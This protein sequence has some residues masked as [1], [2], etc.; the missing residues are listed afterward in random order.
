MNTKSIQST[1]CKEYPNL[2]IIS[3][4]KQSKVFSKHYSN[5]A[6]YLPRKQFVLLSWLVF[7]SGADNTFNHSTHLL[8]QFSAY[9]LAIQS[10]YGGETI[11]TAI[12]LIRKDL[13][14][15]IEQG[16]IFP[17]KDKAL[18]IN[19]MLVHGNKVSKGDLILAG[20]LYQKRDIEV[21]I[22]IFAK[23]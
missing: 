17:V 2:P 23:Y 1:T 21:M 11:P 10:Q 20:E 16:F 5:A 22:N 4:H 13:K 18:M 19:P 9:I 7:Q 14:E 6:L 12:Q 3:S 15:L 8:N